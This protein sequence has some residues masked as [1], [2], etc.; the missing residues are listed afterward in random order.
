[1]IHC[2]GKVALG[3]QEE[4]IRREQFT[5]LMFGPIEN[6]TVDTVCFSFGNGNVAEYQSDILEWPGEADDLHGHRSSKSNLHQWLATATLP[7]VHP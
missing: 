3:N 7:P 5:A 1:M 6:T 2:F 4:P